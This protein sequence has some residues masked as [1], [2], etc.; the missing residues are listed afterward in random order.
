MR[1]LPSD[2]PKPLIWILLI[3][4]LLLAGMPLRH[5]HGLLQWREVGWQ[6]LVMLLLVPA[7]VTGL[8][9]PIWLRDRTAFDLRKAYLMGMFVAVI[10]TLQI[11]HGERMQAR[12][13]HK[14]AEQTAET[15]LPPVTPTS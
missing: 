9:L 10:A 15:S 13:A 5:G 4:V 7:G 8:A 12:L 1:W 14:Q 3:C 11:D 2:I 6:L